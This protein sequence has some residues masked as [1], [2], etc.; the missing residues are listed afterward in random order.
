MALYLE[1]KPKGAIV[2]VG[3]MT[4]GAFIRSFPSGFRREGG[5]VAYDCRTNKWLRS[6]IAAVNAFGLTINSISLEEAQQAAY[7][8]RDKHSVKITVWNDTVDGN[9]LR[10]GR[11]FSGRVNEPREFTYTEKSSG[12]EVTRIEHTFSSVVL[13]KVDYISDTAGDE[14]TLPDFGDAAPAGEPETSGTK[15]PV[16]INDM[17]L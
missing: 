1:I 8:I 7:A 9:A 4:D 5:R 3:N 14:L 13:D 12:K 16:V 15:A 17:A 11:P 6:G 2:E 10:R